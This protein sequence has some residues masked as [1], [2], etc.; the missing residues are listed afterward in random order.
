MFKGNTTIFYSPKYFSSAASL[1]VTSF[2]KP[3]FKNFDL[4]LTKESSSWR[5]IYKFMLYVIHNAQHGEELL[6]HITI[7]N[8][9]KFFSIIALSQISQYHHRELWVFVRTKKYLNEAKRILYH[10]V[11]CVQIRSYFWSVFSCIRTEYG[12]LRV[13]LC[14]ESEYRKIRT[15]NN[16]VYSHNSRR[17]LFQVESVTPK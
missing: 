5:T 3:Y 10:C 16:S 8:S 7:Y 6:T 1:K 2:G 4:Y 9:I 17:G 15:R 12:D 11:K 13:N 14:T